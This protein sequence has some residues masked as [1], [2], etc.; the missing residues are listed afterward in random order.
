MKISKNAVTASK[1]TEKDSPY[2]EAIGHI[3][4][5]IQVLAST[6][7]SDKDKVALDA[8]TNLSVISLDLKSE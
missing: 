5:A 4:K 7:N 1:T 2:T 3:N 8:I 6:V